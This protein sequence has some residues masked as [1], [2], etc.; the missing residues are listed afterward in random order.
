VNARYSTTITSKSANRRRLRAQLNR[1]TNPIRREVL[2]AKIE[3]LGLKIRKLKSARKGQINQ[4]GR[5]YQVKVDKLNSRFAQRIAGTKRFYKSLINLIQ[6]NWKKTFEADIAK[7]QT[8][9]DSQFAAV[10]RLNR[11]G[12]GYIDEMPSPL[13]PS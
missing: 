11:K 6:E 10:K 13:P 8:R 5:Q 7:V 12:V 9:R 1:T 3:N 2:L 4:A